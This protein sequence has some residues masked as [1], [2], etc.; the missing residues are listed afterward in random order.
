M[1]ACGG[2]RGRGLPARAEPPASRAKWGAGGGRG[3]WPRAAAP[4]W[5]LAPQ[6]PSEPLPSWCEGGDVFPPTHFRV[7][8]LPLA[9]TL[10]LATTCESQ[11]SEERPGELGAG[12]TRGPRRR[13]VARSVS[14]ARRLLSLSSF[15][16]FAQV[17]LSSSRAPQTSLNLPP[18]P[19]PA[20]AACGPLRLEV[21]P[22]ALHQGRWVGG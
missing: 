22:R 7:P 4:A 6:E 13:P 16:A 1:R 15:P 20:P 5:S 9:R 19:T 14:G 3:R 10:A 11:T 18:Q 17:G 8:P 12:C 21:R 2:L